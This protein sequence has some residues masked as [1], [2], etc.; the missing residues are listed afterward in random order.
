MI[1][2]NRMLGKW[3][4]VGFRF[5]DGEGRPGR[6]EDAPKAGTL[7]YEPD[8][9]LAVATRQPDG[10]LFGYFGTFE[11]KNDE[12]FHHIELGTDAKLDGT[13]TRRIVSFEGDRLVLTADPPVLGGP[14]SK[15]AL[16]WGRP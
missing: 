9:R 10:K 5:T 11:L 12:V 13:T 14:G 4:L 2:R 3:R 16:I 7:H 1:D 8:G 6:A 15:A